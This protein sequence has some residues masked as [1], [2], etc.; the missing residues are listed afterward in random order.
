MGDVLILLWAYLLTALLFRTRFWFARSGVLPFVVFAAL[1]FA[2]TAAS[3]WFNLNIALS[4]EYA[5][6]MP[7]VLG[8]GLAPLA[9]WV[10]V[11]TLV[12]VVL[13]RGA[14]IQR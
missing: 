14:R 8:I 7:R 10:V 3:E 2:Y 13:R 4:W 12:G 5:P 6:A 11:P 1:G 9:Q